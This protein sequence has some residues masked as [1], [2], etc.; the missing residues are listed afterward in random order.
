[1]QIMLPFVL[2]FGFVMGGLAINLPYYEGRQFVIILP[3]LFVLITL[4]IDRLKGFLTFSA[5]AKKPLLI[6]IVFVYLL[7]CADSLSKIYQSW[8]TNKYGAH[9]P[10]QAVA[11]QS[12]NWMG[13][14]PANRGNRFF[15]GPHNLR[16]L[17]L[18]GF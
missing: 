5:Q 13:G 7:I 14:N 11:K 6:V 8:T 12:R 1:M 9:L 16:P 4:G 17:Q 10:V 2:I 3:S 15:A 18:L